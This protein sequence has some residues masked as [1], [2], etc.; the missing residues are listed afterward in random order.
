MATISLCVFSWQLS[1]C[2]LCVS[3]FCDRSRH[4]HCVWHSLSPGQKNWQP[5]WKRLLPLQTSEGLG[6]P[7]LPLGSKGCG[8]HV[9][10]VFPIDSVPLFEESNRK[11]LQQPREGDSKEKP[12]PDPVGRFQVDRQVDRANKK[13]VRWRSILLISNN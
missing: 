12:W 13:T 6:L 8:F 2:T 11:D 10:F 9:C 5:H 4:R 1:F 7:F 3:R